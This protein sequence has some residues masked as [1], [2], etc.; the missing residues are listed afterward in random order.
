[1]VLY[2]SAV[3]D[4]CVAWRKALRKVWNVPPQTH[5]KTLALLSDSM[6][7]D[8]SLKARF[9]KFAKK[10]ICH[11]NKVIIYVMKI[12]VSNPWSVVG[13]ISRNLCGK[14]NVLN[15]SWNESI[16]KDEICEIVSL[17]ELINV[18]DGHQLC[19]VFTKDEV[20]MFIELLC[21]KLY[22]LINFHVLFKHFFTIV[23]FFNKMCE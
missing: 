6:S 15:D 2:G 18:R 8:I 16:A 21:V 13:R 5:N 9:W 23:L 22:F 1:M 19:H 4:V 14:E 7:L 20:N 3:I 17:K 10:T 12:A 11:R